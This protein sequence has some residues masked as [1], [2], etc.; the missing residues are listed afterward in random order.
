M[1]KDRKQRCVK[2][3]DKIDDNFTAQ[4]L[5]G[6]HTIRVTARNET[7]LLTEVLRRVFYAQGDIPRELGAQSV[8]APEGEIIGFRAAAIDATTL[9]GATVTAALDEADSQN[10]TVLGVE[11]GGVMPI[12]DGIRCW[13]Y[14]TTT[15]RTSLTSSTL[16]VNS[17]SL[18]ADGDCLHAEVVLTIEAA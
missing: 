14:L 6:D 15:P 17:S 9:L 3:E 10:V 8:R 1:P 13:G 18:I 11:I 4:P 12:S 5:S 16:V 7:S 2:P